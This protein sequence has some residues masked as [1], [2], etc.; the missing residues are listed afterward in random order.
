M[1]Y[2]I[3]DLH[4]GDERVMR[5]AGRP[6]A[7]AAQMDR[8]MTDRWNRRVTDEDEIYILGDFAYSDE[9][10]CA[11]LRQLNGR[12]HLILGNHDS[13]LSKSLVLF[14]SV[15]TITK[16]SDDGKT[17]VLCHYPL[18]SYEDSIYGGYQVFGHIHNNP[19]DIATEL[20]KQL[21]RSLHA[22]VDVTD[23]EPRTLN[24][25]M[26]MKETV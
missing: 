17:V 2:Y 7:D 19:N 4:F 6:F 13:V 18:L 22:G 1:I 9:I 16:I 20:Q 24:E 21:V 10:A 8:E 25:L 12:K 5:L 14:E 11:V 26:Q 23:F 15:G 3:A